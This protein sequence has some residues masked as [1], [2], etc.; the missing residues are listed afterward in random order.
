MKKFLVYFW[1]TLFFCA[2]ATQKT[3]ALSAEQ[4]QKNLEEEWQNPKT[5]PLK[6]DEKENFKGI[7]F[8]P[9]RSE[10]AVQ[11]KFNKINDNQ[12]IGFPTS[13]K[14][15]KYFKAYG[16]LQFRIH[17]QP[18]ELT[19]YQSEP[20]IKGYETSLF[21]PF[22]DATNG[23]NTYG[24]GRY[25]DLEMDEIKDGKVI[26]DFNK[27]YN[28]YCAYSKYYNCPIPPANNRLDVEILAGVK[29]EE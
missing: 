2:C 5:T 22:T 7:Q 25:M 18:F 6:E 14:K 15:T 26:L 16:T 9:I 13:A 12:I 20:A 28:P 29:Y 8:F 1:L 10:F 17:D 19:V 21:I 27:A 3:P 23:V 11:A 4:F 24:G